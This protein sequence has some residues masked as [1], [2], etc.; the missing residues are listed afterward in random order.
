MTLANL[1]WLPLVRLKQ[2]HPRLP[3]R[4]PP[5]RGPRISLPRPQFAA[6]PPL[7]AWQTPMRQTD[8]IDSFIIISHEWRA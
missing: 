5:P 2:M 7:A 3:D 1:G 6:C 4:L 8:Q